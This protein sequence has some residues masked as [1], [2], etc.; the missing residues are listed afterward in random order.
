MSD[1]TSCF[2]DSIVYLSGSE[3]HISMG[4]AGIRNWAGNWPCSIL[5]EASRIELYFWRPNGDLVDVQSD[6]D[7]S[8]D[9]ASR[10]L[11]ALAE[12]AREHYRHLFDD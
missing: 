2:T 12:A 1:K 3:A 8:E 6:I 11:A 9:A 4:P 10:E 7:D 5:G